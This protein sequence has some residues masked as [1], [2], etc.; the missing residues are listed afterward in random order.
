V[1][2]STTELSDE[3]TDDVLKL[4]ARLEDDDDVQAVYHNLG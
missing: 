4:I 2:L 1:P 3:Q